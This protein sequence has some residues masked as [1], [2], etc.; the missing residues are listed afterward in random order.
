MT[1]INRQLAATGLGCVRGERVLFQ[2]LG[3]TLR[4]GEVLQIRGINGSG[5][6]SLLRI[7][8]GLL[9]PEP[10]EVYWNGEGILAERTHYLAQLAYLGHLHGMKDDLTVSENIVVSMALAACQHGSSEI[11]AVLNKLGLGSA[12]KTLARQLSAGQKRRLGLARFLLTAAPLWIMDEPF[13]ALDEAG[14]KLVCALIEEHAHKGG[15]C[16]V[17]SHEP[18][19]LTGAKLSGLDL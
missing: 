11:N 19:Q 16:V 5:K 9:P 7:L 2:G 15:L 14:R 13:T 8:C 10:G 1:K 3:F 12:A 6:S 17:A 4:S 18:L